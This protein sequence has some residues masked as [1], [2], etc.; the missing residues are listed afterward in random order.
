MVKKRSKKTA[1]LS[2][3]AKEAGVAIST[4][5]RVVNG[6]S[7]VSG[8]L[9]SRVEKVIAEMG[10]KPEPRE[11][12]K[13]V[14]KD[15]WPHLKYKVFKIVIFGPYDSFWITNYAPIFSYALHGI[16]ERLGMYN[17]KRVVERAEGPE[18]LKEVLDAGGADGFLVLNTGNDEIPEFVT[19][20]P[21]VTFMGSHSTL[22]CDRVVPDGHQAGILAADFLHSKGCK[23]CVAYGG[24]QEVYVERTTF[25]Q[26]RLEAYGVQVQQMLLPDII[27]GGDRMHRANRTAVATKLGPLLMKA[28]R[29]LGIFSL[30]D[31]VTPAIYAELEALGLKIGKDV[32]IVS[33]N[34]ERPYLDALIPQPSAI[35]DTR[36]DYIGQRAVDQLMRRIEFPKVPFEQVRISASLIVAD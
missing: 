26:K 34:N 3:I 5:S 15:P 19:K 36:A 33:C 27:R 29:P 20:Y 21:L 14:R 28:Q 7:L 22:P 25:F 8:E 11:K 32:F 30:M 16:E 12:R 24:K 31:M 35:I 10:Y 17:L 13:G 23:F 6:S 2:D 18:K 9:R 1:N 4:V